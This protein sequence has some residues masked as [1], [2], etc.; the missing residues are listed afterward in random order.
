MISTFGSVVN[1]NYRVDTPDKHSVNTDRPPVA[2][3]HSVYNWD[4]LNLT[5]IHFYDIMLG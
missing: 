2:G 1:I 3:N 4:I 5:M